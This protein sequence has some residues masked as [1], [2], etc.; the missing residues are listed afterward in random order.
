M[1]KDRHTFTRQ[2]TTIMGEG[3]RVLWLA[4]AKR[5]L[6]VQRQWIREH[7]GQ[8]SRGGLMFMEFLAALEFVV[9]ETEILS[10]VLI[11]QAKRRAVQG[12][13]A[14]GPEL[15]FET[16]PSVSVSVETQILSAPA[17]KWCQLQSRI[18]VMREPL[19]Y[20]ACHASKHV[21]CIGQELE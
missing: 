11:S 16:L 9:P 8:K 21:G 14:R 3:R 7:G 15:L 4:K 18:Q 12:P 1:P 13:R 10:R 19:R 2:F 17:S 5:N 6:P 20:R